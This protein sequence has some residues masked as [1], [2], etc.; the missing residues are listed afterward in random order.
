[1]REWIIQKLTSR[2]FWLGVTGVV[3]GLIMMFGV[4]ETDVE[5]ISGALLAIGSAV[6]Y[7]IT[8]G[9]VDAKSLGQILENGEIIYEEISDKK[10]GDEE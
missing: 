1:M 6:G 9:I 2:K 4:A 5:T 8:E 3:S 7:M 10:D